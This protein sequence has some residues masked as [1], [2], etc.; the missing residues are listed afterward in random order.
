MGSWEPCLREVPPLRSEP[1][2]AASLG[3]SGDGI[4]AELLGWARLSSALVLAPEER[5][6]LLCRGED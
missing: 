1:W 2:M 6:W 5:L 3:S 4:E